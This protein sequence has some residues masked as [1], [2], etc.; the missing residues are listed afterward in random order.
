MSSNGS[1]L[2]PRLLRLSL[3]PALHRRAMLL[4][5]LLTLIILL[6]PAPRSSSAPVA[7]PVTALAIPGLLADGWRD[8]QLAQLA[9]NWQRVQQAVSAVHSAI[10][11]D[12]RL[13]HYAIEPGDS[14][15][16]IFSRQGFSQQQLQQVLAADQSLLALDVLRPGHSLT[17]TL[18]DKLQLQA[19]ELYVHAGN[20]V[21]YRREADGE[22]SYQ[23]L[24][25][26]GEWHSTTLAGTISGSFYQSAQQA[27]LTDAEIATVHQL[28]R[29]KLNFSR[30]IQAGARFQVVR[31]DN[32]VGSTATGQSRI[33]GVR[34]FNRRQQLNAFLHDN[35]QFYDASGESLERA[36]MRLPLSRTFRVSDDFNPRR[37]HP[38]TG[39]VRPHN[40]TDFATPTGTAVLAAAEGKVIRVENH[41]FAG[42]YIEIQHHGQFK[43]RYLH[44]QRALVRPG[45]RVERGQRIAL[46]GASGRV[47]GAHLHYELHVNNRPVNPM[48]ANIPLAEPV[49]DDSRDA[50]LQ[51][52]AFMIEQMEQ[53]TALA[54]LF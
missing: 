36:F 52:V 12:A 19:M 1:Q 34:L 42:R 5:M 21:L 37:L 35:G 38:V 40:G 49:P 27:G 15:S 16:R 28:F 3:I 31:S 11:A 4:L 54:Q 6:W 17:F 20:R 2:N 50:F 29:D 39:R 32:Y 47:T 43:T 13:R 53:E 9:A 22:F 18:D 7:A 44:L 51:R 45:Q 48:T 25:D 24:L 10:V 46:S 33:E 8:W 23:E 14:L 26:P 41:P 30:D